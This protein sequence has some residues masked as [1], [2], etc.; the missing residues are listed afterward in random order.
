MLTNI[1]F[2]NAKAM[3]AL[4]ASVRQAFFSL[5]WVRQVGRRANDVFIPHFNPQR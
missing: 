4:S 1:V 5:E 2:V 3:Q